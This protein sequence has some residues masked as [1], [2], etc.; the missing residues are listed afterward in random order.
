MII[1]RLSLF[2]ILKQ[3]LDVFYSIRTNSDKDPGEKV[4]ELAAV[5]GQHTADNANSLEDK[6]VL[7]TFSG[8]PSVRYEI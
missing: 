4:E 2:S 1:Y 3:N 5:G 6:A 8:Q 7:L